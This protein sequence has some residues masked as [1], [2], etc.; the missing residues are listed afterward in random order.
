M[1]EHPKGPVIPVELTVEE[2]TIIYESLEAYEVTLVEALDT[3]SR[4][5][6]PG[7]VSVRFTSWLGIHQAETRRIKSLIGNYR[8]RLRDGVGVE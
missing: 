6:L 3:L 7:V 5:P 2:L 1:A 4:A 8:S